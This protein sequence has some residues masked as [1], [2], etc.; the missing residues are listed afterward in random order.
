[1]SD[2][3]NSSVGCNGSTTI[4]GCDGSDMEACLDN[5]LAQAN[6][7][8]DA[9]FSVDTRLSKVRAILVN[10]SQ[11][12][13]DYD[14]EIRLAVQA[15]SPTTPPAGFVQLSANATPALQFKDSA[16]TVRTLSDTTH[17]HTI[18]N[19][20]NL[21]TTLDGKASSVHTHAATDITSGTLNDARIPNLAASK[22]TSGTLDVARIP[23]LPAS[24]IT[25]GT[26]DNARIP[27]LAKLTLAEQAAAPAT[28]ASGFAELY[29]DTTPALKFKDDGGTVRTLSDTTHVHT[30]ANVTN[31]QTTLDGKASSVHTHAIADVTALQTTLDGKASSVHTHAATDI[32]S[33]TL[34]NA[35][36]NWAAPSAIGGTTP[37]A[38]TF[39][40][41]DVEA[42]QAI[43]TIN[44]STSSAA[45][46]ARML[47]ETGGSLRYYIG[48]TGSETGT[49]AGSDFTIQGYDDSGNVIN[50]PLFFYRASGV[51]V[52][53][54]TY[55]NTITSSVRDLQ[56]DNSGVLGYVA[57]ARKHKH[58]I[59]PIKDTQR[60]IAKLRQL[61]P[62][63][64][65]YK[66]DGDGDGVVDDLLIHY[67]FV[68]EEVEQTFPELVSYDIVPDEG[69]EIIRDE[70]GKLDPSVPTH[71]EIATLNYREMHAIAIAGLQHALDKIDELE[72][73][74]ARLE[75][76]ID[77][78]DGG[79]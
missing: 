1:M 58:K 70:R 65:R 43:L 52:A 76:I 54:P 19:V 59:R 2:C 73:R 16:G 55:S 40:S 63:R 79:K 48:V 44:R 69:A 42:A 67:G 41:L 35:R 64:Y 5:I 33:G 56:I 9:C 60:F 15:S 23:S 17:T 12:I 39:T 47:I 18:A 72:A 27:S 22:I 71:K 51:L 46:R 6:Q 11:F 21:Q 37:A 13:R 30:I 49:N 14:A 8:C 26:L 62:V 31:L 4:V 38:G 29:V 75:E 45:N 7:V 77:R 34:N 24:Q 61:N 25:S 68:A 66:V 74:I 32:T 53:A 78:L 57:S 20:T 10:M 28:P 36:V 50:T 3:V